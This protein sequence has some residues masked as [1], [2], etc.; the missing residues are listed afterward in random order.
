MKWNKKTKA[1]DD[2]ER[3]VRWRA[4]LITVILKQLKPAQWHKQN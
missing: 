4:P 2:L 3:I 1:L